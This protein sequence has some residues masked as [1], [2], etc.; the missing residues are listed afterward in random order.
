VWIRTNTAT[1]QTAPP[2][3]EELPTMDMKLEVVVLPVARVYKP[4]WEYD[5]A[6]LAKE[7]GTH[8]AYGSVTA[9]SLAVLRQVGLHRA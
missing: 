6:T 5:R 1:P 9:A 4:I 2:K 7:F 8:I 3:Q